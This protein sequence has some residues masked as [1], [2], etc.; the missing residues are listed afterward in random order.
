MSEAAGVDLRPVFS[1]FLDQTGTPLVTAKLAS[2]P[3]KAAR[4]RLTQSRYSPLGSSA[5]VD[6]LWQIPVRIRYGD[7]RGTTSTKTLL[8]A[9]VK[10]LPIGTP[11]RPPRWV[12]LNVWTC[13]R[14]TAGTSS[15]PASR[16]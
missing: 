11:A 15:L 4:L 14:A 9:P 1:S 13:N 12:S 10:E 7:D 6:Q 2:P 16:I 8:V 5:S 3:D